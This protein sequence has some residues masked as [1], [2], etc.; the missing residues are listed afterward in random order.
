MFI[1][2]ANTLNTIAPALRDRLELIEV[3]GY[4]VEEKIEIAKKHLIPKQKEQHGLK[5][6]DITLK[7]SLIEK[8][9]EDYTRESGVRSLEKTIA[10][11]IEWARK[12][13]V[14]SELFMYRRSITGDKFFKLVSYSL[15][16]MLDL[17]LQALTFISPKWTLE[18]LKRRAQIMSIRGLALSC[19]PNFTRISDFNSFSRLH[20]G[21]A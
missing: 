20:R 14:R 18:T 3:S 7:T 19:A 16:E 2:T 10:P 5:A 21:L 8:I 13:R 12:P 9:I 17:L 4:L 6:K 11:L 15:E 1:A